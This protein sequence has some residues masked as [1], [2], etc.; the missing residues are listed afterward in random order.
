MFPARL[1]ILIRYNSYR[2]ADFYTALSNQFPQLS[3]TAFPGI[4]ILSADFEILIPSSLHCDQCNEWC[5]ARYHS[6]TQCLGP[7]YLLHTQC[8]QLIHF[9]IPIELG[10]AG[11]FRN[12]CF[13]FDVL[14]RN[15]LQ[16]FQVR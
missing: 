16:F 1:I 14:K 5:G 13:N 15:G 3:A 4:F 9:N 6:R 7:P 10:T 12:G 8:V 2:W 11:F